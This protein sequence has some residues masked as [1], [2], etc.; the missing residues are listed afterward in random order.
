MYVVTL[1]LNNLCKTLGV[2]KV[3]FYFIYF[4]SKKKKIKDFNYYDIY[5]ACLINHD[6]MIQCIG[7][8]YHNSLNN[9]HY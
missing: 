7:D 3:T 2:K 1:F 4:I 6:V 9:F 5:D 8:V